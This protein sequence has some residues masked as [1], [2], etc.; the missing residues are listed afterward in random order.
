VVQVVQP[1]V[2]PALSHR[3]HA[4]IVADKVSHMGHRSANFL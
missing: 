3:L 4:F 2:G 1:L